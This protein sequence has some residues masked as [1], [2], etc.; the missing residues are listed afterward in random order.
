VIENFADR[1]VEAIT[2]KKAPVVV[3]IDP[4]YGKLPAAVTGRSGLDRE[5][6]L[7][8]SLDAVLEFS[9]R[10]IRLVAPYVPAVKINTA[11]FERF[12]WE[13]ME[14][15]YELIQEAAERDLLVIADAKRGD[16]GHTA[17]AYAAAH[18]A[19]PDLAGADD[20]VGPDAVTV[21]GYLGADAL[22]PFVRVAKEEG[23]GMFVLVRTSNPGAA[24]VQNIACSD[25]ATL[26]EHM[27]QLVSQW[28][29][30]DGLIGKGGFSSMGAVV[31]PR[32]VEQALRIRQVLSQAILLVP[33]YGAQ[34]L[35]PSEVGA[36]F[37]SNGAGAIVSASR[38]VI[39]AFE[40]EAYRQ[41]FGEQWEP[42]V[43]QACQDFV[44]QIRQVAGID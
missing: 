1:L 24:D 6:D 3:G 42:C 4:V 26:A 2:A 32:D 17:Q 38:S 41:R 44:A 19:D 40:Q 18:L 8:S 12:Y 9:R 36:C 39:Y 37:K 25:G 28:G 23:K 29:Q 16:V 34:G 22:E 13:G 5:K 10:V 14:G 30:Q 31:A 7:E 20:L 21:N 43:E 11:F 35:G 27:A 33:G 15:Y